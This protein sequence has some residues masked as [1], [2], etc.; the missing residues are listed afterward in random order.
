MTW[1]SAWSA[2]ARVWP[3][4]PRS[5]GTTAR[6]KPSCTTW[7]WHERSIGAR[8]CCS[9]WCRVAGPCWACSDWRRRLSPTRVGRWR[10]RSA[11]EARS[12]RI[13]PCTSW[14]PGSCI[15]PALCL[16]GSRWH[17]CWRRRTG[18]RLMGHP[19]LLAR[20]HHTRAEAQ[21]S[22]RSS[23]RTISSSATASVVQ[24]SC[25]AAV[26]LHPRG[27]PGAPR[28]PLRWGQIDLCLPAHRPAPSG[29]WSLAVPRS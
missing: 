10:W 8:H 9:P 26:S 18:Q 17:P 12:W 24:R 19:I 29:V 22:P 27:R 3:R 11:W 2:T 7:A 15:S 5:T 25:R 23:R 6:S 13:A 20:P 4:K 1:S 28:W 16:P 14:P 21:T